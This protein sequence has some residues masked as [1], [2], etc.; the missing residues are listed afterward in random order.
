VSLDRHLPTLSTRGRTFVLRCALGWIVAVASVS[1]AG[2]QVAAED[3]GLV[4]DYRITHWTTTEGLPQNSV[5]DL[6]ILGNGEMWLAT[7]GGLA[8]FDGQTFKVLDMASAE[9]LSSNRIVALEADGAESF[10][11]LTQ[12]GYLGRVERGVPVLLV[13]APSVS[14]DFLKL[15]LD[16]FGPVF[17]LSLDGRLWQTDG[18]QWRPVMSDQVPDVN[19]FALDANGGG[20]VLRNGGISRLNGHARDTA[21]ASGDGRSLLNRKAGGL[22]VATAHGLDRFVDGRFDHE[23]VRPPLAG[24]LSAIEDSGDGTLWIS[25]PG[26]VSRLDRQPDG[27]WRRSRLPLRIPGENRITSLHEDQA[28]ALWIGTDGDGLYRVDRMPIRRFDLDAQS[29]PVGGLA[30]DGRRGA[31]VSA[32]CKGVFHVDEGGT[33]GRIDVRAFTGGAERSGCSASLALGRDGAVWVRLG[34]TLS[35]IRPGTEDVQLVTQLLPNEQGPVVPDTDGSVWVASRGGQVQLVSPAGTITREL[36]L[37]PR[38]YSASLAADGSLWVGGDGAV[39]RLTGET[40]DRFGQ[41][42]GVPRGIV[43]DVVPEPDGTTWIGTYGGGL[44]RFRSGR[45]V[46][47]TAEQGLPDNSI[48]RILVDGAERLWISTNRGIAVI[49]RSQFDALADGRVGHLTPVVLGIERGMPEANFGSP[50]GFADGSGRLW[51]GT[52]DGPAVV[53]SN[54]FPFTAT[55][56]IVHIEEVRADDRLLPSDSVV[57]VPPL[58]SRVRITFTTFELHHAE[59]LRF[60]YRIEEQDADWIDAGTERHVDWSPAS[61][62]RYRFLVQAR[63]EDGVWSSETAALVLDV[64][65]AWWQT[66]L[67]RSASALAL[68][69]LGV[70]ALRWRIRNIEHRHAERVRV[71]EEQ[72]QSEEHVASMRA[73]LDHVSRAALMGA[74]TASIAH[75]VGQPIGAI[76]N[77]AEAAKRQLPRYLQRPDDLDQ[78]LA[79]IVSDAMRASTVVKGLRGFL[80]SRGPEAGPVDLSA[81]VLEVLPLVRR[82]L[83]DNRVQ[84][85]LALAER[86]PPVE[87]LR[88]QLSQIVINLVVNACEA[89]AGVTGERRITISTAA[90]ADSLV[91]LAVCDTGPGLAPE[92]AARVFEP[93]VTTKPDGLG[94]GL[95][96]CRSIAERHGGRLTAESRQSGGVCMRLTL[97]AGSV[98]QE[99]A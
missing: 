16:P 18:Q 34:L 63:N 97:P 14:A 33:T 58:A 32:G 76:A 43:R 53:D 24:V 50:A 38:L 83:D 41:A 52:I 90:R 10:V 84:V 99:R 49:D 29:L 15:T 57:S 93:F 79:D 9:G 78:L 5:N 81:L 44:G 88:V 3:A 65:P 25:T 86:L 89:L 23:S 73:Q 40:V 21:V 59:L 19:D 46:R 51:F 48:S 56:P 72:R 70:A 85:D 95:A 74:L 30:S 92:L 42:E 98:P 45:V 37:P 13:R 4:H 20:W 26:D 6:V 68:L 66:T 60:R 35:R 91:E 7:F 64:L 69:I 11:F 71:L 94:V 75:E 22:W 31:W 17:G 28:G 54:R 87:G 27:H 55:P 77:N 67:F 62:G 2:A 39:F 61:P 96:V 82:E 8:R 36:S 1:G 47:L 12:E 80:Q